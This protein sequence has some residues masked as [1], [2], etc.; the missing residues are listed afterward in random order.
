MRERIS[1]YQDKISQGSKNANTGE[2]N[3]FPDS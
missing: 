2:I 3:V 1:N